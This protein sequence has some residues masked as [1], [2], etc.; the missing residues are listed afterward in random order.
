[1]EVKSLG[2]LFLF[3]KF[4]CICINT[5]VQLLVYHGIIAMSAYKL[6]HRLKNIYL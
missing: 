1:M 6:F 4:F 3:F 2:F 5:G